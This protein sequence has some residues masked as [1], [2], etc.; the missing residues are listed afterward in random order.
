[1]STGPKYFADL[2]QYS[3]HAFG[4]AYA[5]ARCCDVSATH[6]LLVQVHHGARDV[7]GGVEHCSIVDAVAAGAAIVTC[8]SKEYA[9][10]ITSVMAGRQNG[11]GLHRRALST[12][13]SGP[14]AFPQAPLVGSLTQRK[15]AAVQRVAQGAEVTVLQHQRHLPMHEG[16]M[17]TI[18]TT[19]RG[20][21]TF[22]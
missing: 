7:D 18:S 21:I 16:R 8:G 10:D 5:E 13:N 15:G 6:A 11:H 1:M 3:M 12:C 4:P 2:R 20:V 17:L 9:N 22:Y 14:L 19:T